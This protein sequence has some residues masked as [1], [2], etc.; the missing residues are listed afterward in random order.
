MRRFVWYVTALALVLSG[1]SVQNARAE[2][3]QHGGTYTVNNTNF[4]TTFTQNVTFDG[5]GV[6]KPIDGGLLNIND[7]T[8]ATGPNAEWVLFHFSTPTGGPLAADSTALWQTVIGNIPFVL[9]VVFDGTFS[10]WDVNGQAFSNIQPFGGFTSIET[11]PITGVG[12]VYGSSFA[13][14][15]PFQ[16]PNSFYS[17]VAPWSFLSTG[18]MDPDTANGFTFAL[19]FTQATV[20]E[21]ASLTL[22]GIGLT[23]LA[24]S[25]WRRRK[26]SG[27]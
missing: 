27:D 16:L 6:N 2:L 7:Q 5:T 12:Q 26:Q 21:P 15:S 11:N 1:V 23:G 13:P 18:N 14:G 22:L 25:A 4:P 10:Y 8:F 20:P 24:A 3:V 17:F 19:H 9:P